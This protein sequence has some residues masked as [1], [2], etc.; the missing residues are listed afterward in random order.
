MHPVGQ[1][2]EVDRRCRDLLLRGVVSVREVPAARQVQ[3]HHPGVRRQQRRV[4]RK[5]RRAPGVGLDI[6]PPL[7]LIQAKGV[8]SALLAEVLHLVDDLVATIVA[9]ARLPLGVLIGERGAEAL[10]DRPG[11]EVLRGDELDRPDLPGLLLRHEPRH[12]GVDLAQRL[13]PRKLGAGG[14]ARGDA[15]G[16]DHELGIGIP[17]G[18]HLCLLLGHQPHLHQH[19][20]DDPLK[21]QRVEVQPRRP[22][23]EES[24]AHLGA[25]LDA[26][27]FEGVIRGVGGLGTVEETFRQAGLAQR[28]HALEAAKGVQ[29]HDAGHN[30]HVDAVGSALLHKV[31]VYLRVQEHLRD[32]KL[33]PRIDLLLEVHHLGLEVGVSADRDHLLAGLVL[34][35]P[36]PA[37]LRGGQGLTAA[38]HNLDVVGVALGVA[39][40]RDAKVVTKVGPHVLHEVEGAGEAALCRR[41]LLL[42]AGR[43]PAERHDV[44]H[45]DLLAGLEGLPTH[46]ALLVGAGQVHVR[47]AA[48]LVLRRR[49]ELQRELGGGAA[50]SPGEVGEERLQCLHAYNAFPQ[51]GNT[52][53][54]LWR[55][56]LKGKPAWRR[57]GHQLRNLGIVGKGSHSKRCCWG[58]GW[59]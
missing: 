47:H 10:H 14:G 46:L 13:V 27:G 37:G 56:V 49:G 35:D 23:V 20:D 33:R 28:S 22:A 9:V 34:H 39:G 32:H 24:A 2:L 40:N 55:E 11:G 48:K 57:V 12:D 8:E 30:G 1:C 25:R 52:L 19:A 38:L 18:A 7:C 45:P 43:I 31:Q 53:I 42:A 15:L 36:C 44:A 29:A 26:E 21:I 4:D 51:V 6:H 17:P 5:V 58:R 16:G 50:S 3:A 41:P 59:V 54:G